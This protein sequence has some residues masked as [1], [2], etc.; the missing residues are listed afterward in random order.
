MEINWMIAGP[1]LAGILGIVIGYLM[2]YATKKSPDSKKE[3]EA[4][5]NK[6]EA[7]NRELNTSLEKRK[8]LE[9]TISNLQTR[10]SNVES[11]LASSK[12]KL[13]AVQNIAS[14]TTETVNSFRSE[15]ARR[16]YGKDVI[17]DDLTIVEGITIEIASLLKQNGINTWKEL[18]TTSAER[19]REILTSS[20]RATD[21]HQPATWPDQARLA[22]EGKWEE[23]REWQN[24]HKVMV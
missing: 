18:S 14:G 23:L 17:Q 5:E 7:K 11:E 15:E 6:Y 10:L 9:N 8:E 13:N 24:K 3:L 21:T 2:G 16:A 1:V 19:C 20:G 4:W 12:S 22:Y